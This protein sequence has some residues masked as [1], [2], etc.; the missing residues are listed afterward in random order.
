M[1]APL[2]S[3]LH[4]RRHERRYAVLDAPSNL[5]LR[6]PAPGAVP[7]CHKA[8][9]ALRDA[10]LVARLGATDAGA[11]VPP[12]YVADWEP[13]DGVRN[14][15]AVAEYAGR[16]SRRVAA[17][18]DSGRFPVLLGGDCSILLGPALALRRSGRF[19][20]AYL[21]AHADFRHPGNSPYVS[22]A[23]GED[24]ALV[25]GRGEAY[26]TDIDGL[27]PYMRD[28]DVILLGVRDEEDLGHIAGSG[29]AAVTS[30]EIISGGVAPAL[31][32]ARKVLTR[33]ELDGFWIHADADVLD[34]SLLP[35]V[36]S[37]VPGGLDAGQF[38]ELLR[39]L[40]ALPGA[41]GVEITI[42]DPDLDPD[43]AQ[44]ALLVD[45]ITTALAPGRA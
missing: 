33:G 22:S 36:D 6:P 25:T 43:G 27:R 45:L 17:L 3:R 38:T 4:A 10:G 20:L 9:W 11:V 29:I 2:R 1:I 23:A 24:V 44:A 15:P 39:S 5:G 16:L 32:A 21:D 7:G 34:P 13:G 35:A 40:A 42:L 19:G 14:G 28:E 30:A 18:L 26:L 37:P 31:D 8:P 41:A 12:R